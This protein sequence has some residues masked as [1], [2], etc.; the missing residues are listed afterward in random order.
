[1]IPAFMAVGQAFEGPGVLLIVAAGESNAGG[2]GQNSLATAGE[3]GVRSEVQILNN[4][5][6]LF[7]DLDIDVNNLIDHDGITG[8]GFH[9]IE[10]QLANAVAAGRLS[11]SPVYLVKTGQGGSLISEWEPGH[12]SDYWTKFLERVGAATS[13]LGSGNF[14]PIVF[15]TQGVNDSIGN[16]TY[17]GG[18]V[19]P[20]DAATWKTAT[21]AH[22]ARIRAELGSKTKIVMTKFN[23]PTFDTYNTKI[24]EIVAGDSR[25]VAI[26]TPDHRENNKYWREDYYHWSYTGFKLLCE[27]FI[28]KIL[29]A[30]KT[31]NPTV[32][33]ASGSFA[34][35]QTVTVTGYNS[36]YGLNELDP[37]VGTS[38][39][40][41]SSGR[42]PAL[43][44]VRDWRPDRASSDVV[45]RDYEP[46]SVTTTWGDKGTLVSFSNSD[47]IATNT[48]ASWSSVRSS[49]YFTT[50]KKYFEIEFLGA[51]ANNFSGIGIMDNTT[52]SG[53]GL[54][55]I[56]PN[57]IAALRNDTFEFLTSAFTSGNS[58]TLGPTGPDG[59]EGDPGVFGQIIGCA[60]DIAAGKMFLARNNVYIGSGDPT[61]GTNPRFTWTP[62]GRR[63][64]AAAQMIQWTKLRLIPSGTTYSPPSGYSTWD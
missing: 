36:K 40:S 50:G 61:A 23:S 18:A 58:S 17:V 8:P 11:E 47:M 53:A 56:A 22:L 14:R 28:D 3:L 55:A 34:S 30:N 60:V 5:T 49:T 62:D 31:A 45:T 2:I 15:Y 13:I 38:S 21:I 43:V 52:A 16:S 35:A 54:D 57:H 7:E 10:L 37:W 4:T 9:G 39:S 12:A 44:S 42:L 24:D 27:L 64:Y 48:A 29:A 51:D 41:F 32:S 63:I 1:M 25:T 19:T 20:T 46:S 26:S 6:L 33:P 59:L